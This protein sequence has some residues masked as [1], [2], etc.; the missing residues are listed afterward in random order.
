MKLWILLVHVRIIMYHHYQIK[1]IHKIMKLYPHIEIKSIIEDVDKILSKNFNQ[2]SVN[3]KKLPKNFI[4]TKN[5]N[6][7]SYYNNTINNTINNDATQSYLSSPQSFTESEEIINENNLINKKNIIKGNYHEIYGYNEKESLSEFLEYNDDNIIEMNAIN[8]NIDDNNKEIEKNN[9]NNSKTVQSLPVLI[10]TTKDIVTNTILSQ[11]IL[12]SNRHIDLLPSNSVFIPVSSEEN[13]E[14][15]NE[16]FELNNVN[17]KR[18]LQKNSKS[19]EKTKI[20][21][22]STTTEMNTNTNNTNT[23]TNTNINTNTNT[24]TNTNKTN[25]NTNNNNNNNKSNN[26]NNCKDKDN[27]N[28]N[29]MTELS[30]P[31]NFTETAMINNEN[32]IYDENIDGDEDEY[33]NNAHLAHL[34]RKMNDKKKEKTKI[35]HEIINIDNNKNNNITKRIEEKMEDSED[36][37]SYS[38]ENNIIKQ[39]GKQILHNKNYSLT[40]NDLEYSKKQN[41]SPQLINNKY[42]YLSDLDQK[43]QQFL[44]NGSSRI[45]EAMNMNMEMENTNSIVEMLTDN[46]NKSYIKKY[47]K[48]SNYNKSYN[49][50][51]SS[52]ISKK[53]LQQQIV[54]DLIGINSE[55]EKIA[56]LTRE[57]VQ[58][59]NI[60]NQ[61]RDSLAFSDDEKVQLQKEFDCFQDKVEIERLNWKDEFKK[62]KEIQAQDY[63]EKVQLNNYIK[64]MEESIKKIHHDETQNKRIYQETLYQLK[65]S[66]EGY[67]QLES[68]F[69]LLSKKYKEL[70]QYFLNLKQSNEEV[71]Q[72]NKILKDTNEE[73][74]HINDDLKKGNK[75]LIQLNKA[76]EEENKKNDESKEQY[77]KEESENMANQMQEI[78]QKNH[79]YISQINKMKSVQDVIENEYNEIKLLLNEERNKNDQCES[80]LSL[81]GRRIRTLMEQN[82]KLSKENDRIRIELRNLQFNP[83]LEKLDTQINTDDRKGSYNDI[84]LNNY[85]SSKIRNNLVS[86]S[87][88]S[89]PKNLR[90]SNS[91]SDIKNVRWSTPANIGS[92]DIDDVY[93]SNIRSSFKNSNIP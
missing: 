32:S 54:E 7:Q 42:D 11:N 78:I 31:I 38:N 70:E 16:I 10:P 91:T 52:S 55:E 3:E 93:K 23:N 19:N 48:N 44:L 84:M 40:C 33:I 86:Y 58:A 29:T 13:S 59:R 15:E 41:Y 17:Q 46:I 80:E 85:P 47:D 20:P 4:N 43:Q 79:E 77:Y 9:D 74:I 6:N 26:I 36:L 90:N 60:I 12:N 64:E 18:N 25:T 8:D 5:Y 1:I 22:E 34:Q 76:L 88:Y 39:K 67:N 56:Q 87:S 27:T 71:L 35:E 61:L 69:N 57:L 82:S 89:V 63:K 49:I 65:E 68:D 83:P 75:H 53:Q 14:E 50:M 24:N 28:I 30:S 51:Q 81:F 2:K 92:N 37:S 73:L 21:S 66:Q 72:E 45:N 62:I